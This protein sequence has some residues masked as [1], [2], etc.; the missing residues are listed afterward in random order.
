M[1]NPRGRTRVAKFGGILKA[2]QVEMWEKQ[3]RK[4]HDSHGSTG[5]EM[6]SSCDNQVL[7]EE[8]GCDDESGEKRDDLLGVVEIIAGSGATKLSSASD[9]KQIPRNASDTSD[10]LHSPP[11][12]ENDL[13]NIEKEKGEKQPSK[14]ILQ[15][16]RLEVVEPLPQFKPHHTTTPEVERDE[17]LE[18]SHGP[19]VKRLLAKQTDISTDD[20]EIPQAPLAPL[21][22]MK[23][24]KTGASRLHSPDIDRPGPTKVAKTIPDSK[25]QI[26]IAGCNNSPK[27]K[28]QSNNHQGETTSTSR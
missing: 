17:T 18:K 13:M 14:T 7:D 22:I 3:K 2:Q 21:N 5:D 16:H 23:N 11:G 10:H 19:S 28:G 24:T 8:L 6:R 15:S 9:E 12:S 25:L 26:V 4:T 1:V 20:D 27:F